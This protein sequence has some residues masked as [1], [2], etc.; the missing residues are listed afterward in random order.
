MGANIDVLKLCEN[1]NKLSKPVKLELQ[2]EFKTKENLHSVKRLLNKIEKYD[3]EDHILYWYKI[4]KEN[5]KA[6]KSEDLQ[7]L[8][9]GFFW[10]K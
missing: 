3:E 10:R 2:D 7:F 8:L 1:Q 6:G 9:N 4:L 5:P